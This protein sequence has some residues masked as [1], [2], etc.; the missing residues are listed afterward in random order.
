MKN[1]P[2][3]KNNVVRHISYFEIHKKKQKIMSWKGGQKKLP[4]KLNS[5]SE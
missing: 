5:E 3:I 1:V 4:R 2:N